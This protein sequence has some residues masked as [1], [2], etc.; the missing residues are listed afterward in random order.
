MGDMTDLFVLYNHKINRR[1]LVGY[2]LQFIYM[3]SLFSNIS[4][5]LQNANQ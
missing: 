2:H 4:F 1:K 3:W 5:H